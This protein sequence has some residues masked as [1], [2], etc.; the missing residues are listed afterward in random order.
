MFFPNEHLVGNLSGFERQVALGVHERETWIVDDA[1]PVGHS[2]NRDDGAFEALFHRHYPGA[3]AHL[4]P[5]PHPGAHV[6]RYGR[7]PFPGCKRFGQ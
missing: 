7:K 1:D 2:L 5:L 6:L 3:L 4:R